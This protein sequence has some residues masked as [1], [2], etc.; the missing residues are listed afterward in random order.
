MFKA[1]QSSEMG[2]IEAAIGQKMRELVDLVALKEYGSDGPPKDLTWR[3]IETLGHSTGQTMA[4]LISAAIQQEHQQHFEEAQACP[5]CGQECCQSD[6]VERDL[7][8]VDGNVRLNEPRFHCN[9]CRRSFF[10]SADS[11]ED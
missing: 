4:Q 11:L 6:T 5:Q 9:A 8:T 2:S 7:K 1:E 3:Q 10:P